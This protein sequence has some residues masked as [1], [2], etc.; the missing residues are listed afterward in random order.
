MDLCLGSMLDYCRKKLN[1][2]SGLDI[3]KMMWEITR[4]LEYLH[5]NNIVHGSLVL[6][7]I[8]LW[9]EKM[10]GNSNTIVKIALGFFSHP[11]TVWRYIF[12]SF[13]FL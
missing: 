5:E 6:D 11:I 4:G 12:L 1:N 10:E 13:T 9:N 3:Y 8:L 7:K 2:V